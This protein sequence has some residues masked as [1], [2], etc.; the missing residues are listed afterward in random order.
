MREHVFQN[1]DSRANLDLRRFPV[2]VQAPA[3]GMPGYD[4]PEKH[5]PPVSAQTFMHCLR[6]GL[7]TDEAELVV[8]T[9]AA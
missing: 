2:G 1:F 8:F 9:Q 4:R 5:V 6:G 3:G 7:G